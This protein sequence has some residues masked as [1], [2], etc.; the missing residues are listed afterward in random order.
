MNKMNKNINQEKYEKYYSAVSYL[1]SLGNIGGGYQKTNLKSHPHPEM[2]IERM[3][4][5]LKLVGNPENNF[6]FIHITGTSGKGGVSSSIH[7]S[8]IISGKKT[9]L[10]TSPFVVSTIEKIKVGDK[11]I[12]PLVFADIT[13]SLKPHID[14][15]I[16]SSK[17]GAPSYFE[18]IFTIALIYFKMEKC[19]YVVLEVGLGG[20]YDATNIIKNPLVTAITNID[21]DHTNI[22]GKN[23][24][25]IA[26]DKIGIV[27][28]GSTFFTTEENPKLIEI[29]K[30]TCKEIGVNVNILDV[31]NLNYKERNELLVN[32]ICKYL[33]IE[34]NNEKFNKKIEFKNILPA[35]FEIIKNNP[36]IIIDGAH[37]PS[38]IKST[39]YNLSKLKYNK[40][41]VLFAI[42]ADKDWKS[43][44]KM[45]IPL[46]D[47]IY[48]TRFGIPGRNCISLKLLLNSIV[49][50]SKGKCKTKLYSDP[51]QAFLKLKEKL[52]KKDILLVTG[53][54]YLAGDIRK[55]YCSEEQILKQRNSDIL[56]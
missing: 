25:E 26:R 52:S 35:R 34:S 11:Y 14:E 5:F 50:I 13:E 32:S 43:V 8:L 54:F 49:E 40:L 3:K 1:E 28:K 24:E 42:S 17:H 16:R 39:L 31:K 19:E 48:V 29:F 27:K 44:I 45:I 36:H 18:L 10:F 21:L 2:F 55:L 9:G 33:K 38:K 12:D 20:R 46:A 22:L 47:T 53:S 56:I 30:K 37:N 6:K 51:V 15:S 23:V 7:S 41:Y 4:S